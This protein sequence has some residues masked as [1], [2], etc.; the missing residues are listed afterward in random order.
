MD[1]QRGGWHD[2]HSIDQFGFAVF[3]CITHKVIGSHAFGN[4]D[5]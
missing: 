4:F 5:P 3:W 2:H 1:R